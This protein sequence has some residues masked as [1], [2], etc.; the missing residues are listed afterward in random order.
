MIF[1]LS[2]SVSVLQDSIGIP[3]DNNPIPAAVDLRNVRL[4]VFFFMASR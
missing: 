3:V 1:G 4:V 2:V